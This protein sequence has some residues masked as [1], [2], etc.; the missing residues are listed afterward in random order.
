MNKFIPQD[1]G[2]SL[3]SWVDRFEE[4]QETCRVV[5]GSVR[6]AMLI[7]ATKPKNLAGDVVCEEDE[8]VNACSIQPS[9]PSKL[10]I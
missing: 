9:K 4:G 1:L 10:I 6:G 3:R 2:Q 7:S 8:E 5:M